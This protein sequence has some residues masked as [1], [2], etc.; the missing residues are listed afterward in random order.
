MLWNNR[1]LSSSSVYSYSK[2]LETSFFKNL[3]RTCH[4][5]IQFTS[6]GMFSLQHS[7]CSNSQ[8]SQNS[9]LFNGRALI[10]FTHFTTGNV[11]GCI[12]NLLAHKTLNMKYYEMNM[13][14]YIS[15]NKEIC[16]IASYTK[17]LVVYTISE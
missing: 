12:F 10:L 13:Y 11:T 2:I 7:K 16:M 17:C 3:L 8:Y 9:R 15:N 5:E 1:G 14:H 6:H 4:L